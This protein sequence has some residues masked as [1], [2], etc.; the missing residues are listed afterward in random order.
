[1]KPK[2]QPESAPA[3]GSLHTLGERLYDEAS[4]LQPNHAFYGYAPIAEAEDVRYAMRACQFFLQA[5]REHLD[6]QAAADAP[7]PVSEPA[8]GNSEECLVG[9]AI[10]RRQDAPVGRVLGRPI[11]RQ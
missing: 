5:A 2:P 8:Q 10:P 7:G 9:P 3:P 11:A 6:K 1:M 4:N